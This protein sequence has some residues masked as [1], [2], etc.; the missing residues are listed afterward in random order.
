M[1]LHAGPAYSEGAVSIGPPDVPTT[2]AAPKAPDVALTAARWLSAAQ[3]R[4]D[5]HYFVVAWRGEPVGAIFLH[6]IDRAAGS[7]L[8]GYHLF[9]PR[10]RGRGI[11]TAALALLL[12]FVVEQTDL[13]TL[14]IITSRD[15]PASQRIA[16]KCG[17]V[18]AGAPREDPIDG[19][20]F[21]WKRPTTPDAGRG[22]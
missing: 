14:V 11:G 22:Q 12:R 4:E 5:I 1:T 7:S 19:M 6:D 13:A 18:D 9:E 16:R 15:N 20:V 2:A 21:R 8:V 17:F 10:W 3:V